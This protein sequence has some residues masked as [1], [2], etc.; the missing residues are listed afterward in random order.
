MRTFDPAARPAGGADA[1]SRRTLQPL[2]Y[3]TLVALDAEQGPL[4]RLAIHW[5]SS[6]D[7]TEWR[8][9]LRTGVRLHDASALDPGRVAAALRRPDRA[10]SVTSDASAVTIRFDAPA[11][12][13]PWRLADPSYAVAFSRPQGGEPIGTG[14]FAIERSEPRRLRLRAHEEHWA[15][16]PFVDAVVVEMGRSVSE[17]LTSLELGR[18]DFVALQPQDL[19][20]AAQRGF[21]TVA[22]RPIELVALQFERRAKVPL[23]LRRALSLAIDRGSMCD[24][25]LQR[26]AIPASTILPEWIGGYASLVP[27][28]LDRM[29]ARSLVAAEPSARRTLVVSS[30]PDPLVRLI[31]DRI[32]VDAREVGLA[33]VPP[34]TGNAPPRQPD[35]RVVRVRLQP[36]T[37]AWTLAL[38]AAELDRETTAPVLPASLDAVYRFEATLR[39]DYSIVPL[40]HLREVYATTPAVESWLQPFVLP[41]GEWNLA[42]VW[43][44]TD[45]P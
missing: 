19:R 23:R 26:Q 29:Q 35:V 44:R 2:I 1:A 45:K 3:E 14:P 10:W 33:L 34:P 31:V 37:P 36:N 18:A 28:P 39:D 40:V 25:L 13:V 22:T 43:L 11:P 16:R 38:A 4:P 9:E 5:T 15:G 12:D 27:A 42:D 30:D 8:F 20:R 6:A 41:S 24:V 21:R 7:R 17:Q 32:A